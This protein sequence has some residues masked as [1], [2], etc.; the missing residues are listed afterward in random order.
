M[1]KKDMAVMH[2]RDIQKVSSAQRVR[3]VLGY[4]LVYSFLIIMA[5]IVLFPFYFMIISSLKSLDEYRLPVPTLIPQQWHFENYADILFP[6]EA[7]PD[8]DLFTLLR[9]PVDMD[10][11]PANDPDFILC[12]QLTAAHAVSSQMLLRDLFHL[13]GQITGLHLTVK[14]IHFKFLFKYALRANIGILGKCHSHSPQNMIL[15]MLSISAVSAS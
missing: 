14:C 2:E 4:V 15:L 1:A 3:K 12:F 8:F 6:K 10:G 13:A 9:Q 11:R 5:L 7:N